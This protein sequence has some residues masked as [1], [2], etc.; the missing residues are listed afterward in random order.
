VNGIPV[1]QPASAGE[2]VV[3]HDE[4]T[5]PGLCPWQ[6]AY[7]L[8]WAEYCGRPKDADEQHCP[9]HTDSQE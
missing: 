7:G 9:E 8:P 3:L 6:T 4:P 5:D 1:Q 2:T